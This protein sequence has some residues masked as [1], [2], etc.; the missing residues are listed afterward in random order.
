MGALAQ[1]LP[2][3]QGLTAGIDI[4]YCG[5]RRIGS[6]LVRTLRALK[7]QDDSVKVMSYLEAQ[8]AGGFLRTRL[9]TS[10]RDLDSSGT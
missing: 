9:R 5:D 10:K 3:E 8:A 7:P 4:C 2:S 1:L 6:A